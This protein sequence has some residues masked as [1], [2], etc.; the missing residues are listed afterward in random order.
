M[1]ILFIGTV[2]FSFK[3][4]KVL[5]NIKANIVGV[6]TKSSSSFNSDYSDLKSLCDINSIPCRH[7]DYINSKE[8]IQW[9][10]E[11][12]P[13]IIFCFGW[14]SLIK[15]ELLNIAP[16]GVIG[17]HPA[18]LPKN[19]GR[20]PLIWALSLGLKETASTFF[21]M[22]EEADSGDIISQQRIEITE[23]DDAQSLYLKMIET[24][25]S[26]ILNIIPDLNTKKFKRIQQK[27][28]QSNLWRKRTKE[29]GKIDWRM[30]A[31]QIHNLVRGLTRPY[32]G[33]HFLLE[34]KEYK[35]WKT[36]MISCEDINNIEPGKV[37]KV[38]SKTFTVKC[39]E[40]CIEV[41]KVTPRINVNVGDY[42]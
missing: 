23:Q 35:V 29:D 36:K 6:C 20:H 41:Q 37:V 33:A 1:K 32:V 19:R 30:N 2:D 38:N 22:D 12:S 42:L 11:L 5:I 16:M 3:I 10:D 7:V 13:D 17:Y 4:L 34:S 27:N 21:F 14:S 39:G 26:Q 25:T 28:S 24:A 9:I 40:G 15:K 8:N 31:K 18:K